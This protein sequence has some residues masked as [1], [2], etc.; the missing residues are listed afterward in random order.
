MWFPEEAAA[1]A[2]EEELLDWLLEGGAAPAAGLLSHE[3]GGGGGGGG[4]DL[5]AEWGLR[6]PEVPGEAEAAAAAAALEDWLSGLLSP[7]GD[8]EGGGGGGGWLLG[9]SPPGS[10]ASS[11]PSE[12]SSCTGSP[13]ALESVRAD[14]TYSLDPP[15][16]LPDGDVAIDLEM[17][18]DAETLNDS[19][20]SHG[21]CDFPVTVPIEESSPETGLQFRF[22]ELILTVEERR[23][24]EKEGVSIPSN[25]PLTKAEER[26]LKR[27]RRKIRNKQSAQ[28]S[29]RRKKV[30]VDSLESR[31]V[32]CTAQNSEL[33]KQVQLLQKQ[34][35][36]LLAQLQK[37]Q[38]LF[39]HSSTKTTTAG[40]CVMVLLLSFCLIL[41]PSLH[42]FGSQ[43]RQLELQG[44]LSRRLRGYPG[45]GGQPQAEVPQT[46]GA[47]SRPSA[48][49]LLHL[50]ESLPGDAP[51]A[52]GSLNQSLEDSRRPPEAQPAATANSSSSG[53]PSPQPTGLPPP[54]EPFLGKR[55]AFLPTFAEQ[56]QSWVDQT[57][58][59][60]IQPHHSDEM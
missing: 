44:V 45:D 14:H 19:Y 16:P 41:L 50:E 23:L 3:K 58:S 29:R 30:Y 21:D 6:E 46:T 9:A 40:T 56:K 31:V 25:L 33:Q 34:N 22:P 60:I 53:D 49:H 17:W 43:E 36:S 2:A 27:V 24:L 35:M 42:P 57:T 55:T 12:G 51:Q 32:A 20:S 7:S 8:E 37:L 52:P 48:G 38:A 39:R 11:G 26:V 4:G 5:L 10:D 28:D 15:Q 54:E 1:A 59:V 13:P 18:G 47:A